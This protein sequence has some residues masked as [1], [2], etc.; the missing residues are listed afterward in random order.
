M[1]A[2][3]SPA[4]WLNTPTRS[5][6]PR[7]PRARIA[8][9]RSVSPTSLTSTPRPHRPA[10]AAPDCH[11]HQPPSRRLS[12][13]PQARCRTGAGWLRARL[14]VRARFVCADHPSACH[15]GNRLSASRAADGRG[16]RR[17]HQR[18]GHR[19]H[20]RPRRGAADGRRRTD[21][22]RRAGQ[23]RGRLG[24]NFSTGRRQ[25]LVAVGAAQ[26]DGD[27]SRNRRYARGPR[28]DR[29][30]GRRTAG[31]LGG[32]PVRRPGRSRRGQTDVPGASAARREICHRGRLRGVRAGF[33]AA[34]VAGGRDRQTTRPPE[35][36]HFG[37]IPCRSGAAAGSAV[38]RTS[39]DAQRGTAA[40]SGHAPGSR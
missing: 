7:C 33:S 5:S 13:L 8:I 19:Q 17:D 25:N 21:R 14:A 29:V 32:R 35:G 36:R 3:V 11:P 15:P 39:A 34:V 16:V 27:L 26:F 40:V 9:T 23:S 31:R 2:P 10:A 18:R 30:H 24:R 38:V 22:S 12:L 28:R 6:W 20:P 4:R 37:P 1:V